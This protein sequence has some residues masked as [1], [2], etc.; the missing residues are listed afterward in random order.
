VRGTVCKRNGALT[1]DVSG[2]IARGIQ[3]GDRVQAAIAELDLTS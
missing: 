2:A 1:A 3:A